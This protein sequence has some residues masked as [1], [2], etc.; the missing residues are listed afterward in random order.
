MSR[1]GSGATAARRAVAR[2]AGPLALALA[3]AVPAPGA[4][5]QEEVWVRRMSD[6]VSVRQADQAYER[7]LYYFAPIAHLKQ[8]DEVEE[9]SAGQI[10]CVLSGGGEVE[11]HSAGH[12][13]IDRL[14]PEGDIL[15]FPILTRLEATSVQ[16]PLELV[17]PGGTRAAFLGTKVI[18]MA[19]PGRMLVRNDGGQAVRLTGDLRLFRDDGS[20]TE[21][22]GVIDVGRGE[23]VLFRLFTSAFDE[24][25]TRVTAWGEVAVRHAPSVEVEADGDTLRLAAPAGG[26]QPLYATV[27]GVRT[28]VGTPGK[29]PGLLIRDPRHV[30]IPSGPPAPPAD[31]GNPHPSRQE[32]LDALEA[33]GYV[34][35][36]PAAPVAPDADTGPDAGE[37]PDDGTPPDGGGSEPDD[38]DG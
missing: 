33:L 11:M 16:R 1:P 38:G 12:M 37:S 29:V 31:G 36:E 14:S 21:P 35:V 5:A 24:S 26:E 6:L 22:Q 28:R 3:L 7:V 10:E 27:R 32:A 13:I 25:G 19:E 2:L 23:Q 8:G 4:A 30:E 15:R 34:G 20:V 9:G 17:L 18:V